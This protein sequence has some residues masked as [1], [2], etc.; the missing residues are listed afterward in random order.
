MTAAKR[1]FCP[2]CRSSR[3]VEDEFDAGTYE[4][5]SEMAWWVTVLDCGHTIESPKRVVGPS[6]GAPYAGPSI[7]V[8]ASHRPA[9]LAAAKAEMPP[10]DPAQDPWA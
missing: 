4:G 8:A 10:L 1:T 7:P 2:T 9:D 3:V 6:P 5:P